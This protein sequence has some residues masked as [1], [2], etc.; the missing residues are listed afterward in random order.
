MY[1]GVVRKTIS[2]RWERRRVGVE[3]KCRQMVGNTTRVNR[4]VAARTT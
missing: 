4:P 2:A 1:S 3:T